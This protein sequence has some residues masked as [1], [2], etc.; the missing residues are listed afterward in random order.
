[1]VQTIPFEQLPS[2]FERFTNAQVRG[3]VVVDLAS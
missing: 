3:R 1:M 2:V